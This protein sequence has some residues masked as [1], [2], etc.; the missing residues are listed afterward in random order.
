MPLVQYHR[1]MR[2]YKRSKRLKGRPKWQDADP[3]SKEGRGTY[4]IAAKYQS[5][6]SKAFLDVVRNLITPE[7]SKDFLKA[8]KTGSMTAAVNSIP[9]FTEDPDDKVWEKFTDRLST[10]YGTVIQAA[11]DDATRDLNKDFDTDMEFS[12]LPP[13]SEVEILKGRED[14]RRAAAGMTVG[15]NPY[16]VEWVKNR[17]LELVTQSIT[18][19]Q[20]QVVTGIIQDAME[21]GAR[22]TDALASIKANIG[23]TARDAG[24]ATKRHALHLE[25]G[26]S[27]ERAEALTSKYRNKL[28]S[29]RAERI[30]RTETIA[31]QAQGRKAAWQVAQDS[32]ALPNVQRRWMAP[33]P[34]PNPN[35]PCEICLELDG[36]TALLNEPYE[37]IYIGFVESPPS[38]PG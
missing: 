34:S 38:H 33:P 11:G 26:L 30:A 15:V 7:I 32:G 9:Y 2:V 24:A 22:P 5:T 12:A 6:F 37:S 8:Y 16:S 23:L 35:A 36:M 4:A 29:A 27:P 14:V 25:A 17:S 31:A 10:A 18:A 20:K 28:L 19:Q 1:A 21:I 3:G 13:K